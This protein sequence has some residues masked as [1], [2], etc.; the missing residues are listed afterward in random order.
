[1]YTE[2]VLSGGLGLSQTDAY[3]CSP[4]APIV[5]YECQCRCFQGLNGNHDETPADRVENPPCGSVILAEGNDPAYQ[6][7]VQGVSDCRL[8]ERVD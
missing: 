3:T 7:K 5:T 2:E 8:R 1:M 6:P 4:L